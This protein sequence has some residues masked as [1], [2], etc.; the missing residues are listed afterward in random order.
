VETWDSQ[1]YVSVF[2][3]VA[4]GDILISMDHWEEIWSR[5]CFP[6][7]QQIV[8]VRW[9]RIE[10]K[11]VANFQEQTLK[12][13]NG[14]FKA[15]FGVFSNLRK[16]ALVNELVSMQKIDFTRMNQTKYY[17]AWVKLVKDVRRLPSELVVIVGMF[18]SICTTGVIN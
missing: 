13:L 14:K 10:D 6:T 15:K 1:K 12:W 16:Q 11:V 3:D 4:P 9:S 7:V 5:D 2:S 18:C 8:S 17:H